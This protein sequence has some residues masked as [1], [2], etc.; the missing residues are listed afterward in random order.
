M[1]DD[2]FGKLCALLAA[3]AWALGVP[4]LRRASVDVHP[5]VSCLIRNLA[6]CFILIGIVCCLRI[7]VAESLREVSAKRHILFV[8]SGLIGISLADSCFFAGARRLQVGVI[9]LAQTVYSPLVVFFSAVFLHEKLTL[10]QFIGGILVVCSTLLVKLTLVRGEQGRAERVAL[11]WMVVCVMSNV[12]AVL[13]IKQSIQGF[14][15]FVLI[16]Y[17]MIVGSLPLVIW[18]LLCRRSDLL[19]QLLDKKIWK[20]L[21]LGAVLGSVISTSLWITGFAYTK[22]SLAALINESSSLFLLLIGW[23]VYREAMTPAKASSAILAT[24]G[25]CLLWL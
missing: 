19:P 12:G 24:A 11:I 16:P 3:M 23:V 9:G 8:L 17:R 18:I 21:F 22:A 6:A 10:T 1:S 2:T 15:I 14:P 7:P 4:L 25:L 5:I 20:G 13:L